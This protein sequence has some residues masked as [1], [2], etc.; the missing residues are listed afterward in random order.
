MYEKDRSDGAITV[1]M[2]R[3]AES[4]AWDVDKAVQFWFF[5]QRYNALEEQKVDIPLR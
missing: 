3:S 2:T 4:Y 5:V 1:V